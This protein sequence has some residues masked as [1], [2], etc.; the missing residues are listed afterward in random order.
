MPSDPLGFKGESPS[1]EQPARAG[2]TATIPADE[3]RQ[4]RLRLVPLHFSGD[5]FL[6]ESNACGNIGWNCMVFADGSV[7]PLEFES[8][9]AEFHITPEP[10]A[11]SV[12]RLLADEAIHL[13]IEFDADSSVFFPSNT[14]VR[15]IPVFRIVSRSLGPA[16]GVQ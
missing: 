1:L 15:L 11:D 8:V 3:Y 16:A 10:G 6:P 14:A 5:D 2:V 13:A 4:L 9:G 12:F 7:R